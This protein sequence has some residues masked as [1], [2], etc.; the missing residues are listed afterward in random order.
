MRLRCRER[1]QHSMH[2]MPI[3]SMIS[4]G[5]DSARCCAAQ[6]SLCSSTALTIP[7]RTSAVAL[8]HAAQ[9]RLPGRPILLLAG[10]HDSQHKGQDH[11]RFRRRRPGGRRRRRRRRRRRLGRGRGRPGRRRRRPGAW[12][13]RPQALHLDAAGVHHC[14]GADLANPC[15]ACPAGHHGARK[16]LRFGRLALRVGQPCLHHNAAARQKAPLLCRPAGRDVGDAD[17]AGLGAACSSGAGG[18]G[19]S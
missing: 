8:Q 15:C 10:A 18:R 14:F 9:L 17:D 6:G 1:V 12:W 4:P 16:L 11:R 5:K 13:R 3:P 7:L 2:V 19:R